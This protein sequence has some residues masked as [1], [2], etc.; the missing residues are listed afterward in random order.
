MAFD[1]NKKP[2]L[3]QV[4]DLAERV[5]GEM[6]SLAGA[7]PKKVSELTNDAGYQTAADVAAAVAATS[8]LV[9]K[10]V[11]STD[12]I[13]MTAEDADRYIYM[14]P[15][16]TTAK[17]RNKYDEYMIL[18][19]ELEHVGDTE[20]DLS[21]YVQ[22]EDGKGLSSNDF[23]NEDKEKLGKAITEDDMASDEEFQEMLDQV[24]GSA[25]TG[26]ED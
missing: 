20:V 11:E 5:N 9:R 6:Q 2:N 18:E 7:V 26:S 17:T 14:V 19:G 16:G 8:H 3:K 12:A 4:M 23:T 1:P 22:K 21:G 25:D 15:K 13:D 10:I 24:F